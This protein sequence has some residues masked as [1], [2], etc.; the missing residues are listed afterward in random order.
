MNDYQ[1]LFKLAEWLD[2][3]DMQSGNTDD[4]VQRDLRRIAS[5]L[6][7]KDKR[8]AKLEQENKSLRKENAYLS[9]CVDNQTNRA[10]NA[11]SQAEMGRKLNADL[12]ARLDEHIRT[13]DR[14]RS[15]ADKE[16]RLDDQYNQGMERALEIVANSTNCMLAEQAIREEIK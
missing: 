14:E 15:V 10:I 13:R 8:I 3:K 1:K 5:E 9:A 2:L 11:E 12:H 6:E 4:E 16:W 7:D